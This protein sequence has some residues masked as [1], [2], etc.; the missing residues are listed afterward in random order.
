MRPIPEEIVRDTWQEMARMPT[1]RFARL[2]DRMARRQPVLLAYLMASTEVD[3]MQQEEKEALLYMG[4]VVWQMMSQGD[5]PLYSVT[6]RLLDHMETR[7]EK[8]LEYLA[9]ETLPDLIGSVEQI[10]QN[11]NQIGVLQ[12]VVAALLEDGD[13]HGF[14]EMSKGYILMCLKTVIDCLDYTPRKAQH[15]A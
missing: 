15:G 13:E 12:Y 6:E 14:S 9:G 5:R 8:M 3:F 4:V 2:V 10:Y 7:N 1:N 11:Y